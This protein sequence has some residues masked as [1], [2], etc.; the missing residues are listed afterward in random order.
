MGLLIRPLPNPLTTLPRALQPPG[1]TLNPPP[2][3]PEKI[4]RLLQFIPPVTLP[5]DRSASIRRSVVPRTPQLTRKA[6][7]DTLSLPRKESPRQVWST[8]T[9]LVTLETLT[10]PR[11]TLPTHLTVSLMQISA[12]Q[13]HPVPSPPRVDRPLR[14]LVSLVN[15]RTRQVRCSRLPVPESRPRP[16]TQLTRPRTTPRLGV[17]SINRPPENLYLPITE[18]VWTL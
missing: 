17:G 7:V 18:R 9:P 11:H 5:I 15:N 10:F 4:S 12:S 6:R 3:V 14:K 13:V 8:L 2:K 16:S 1:S